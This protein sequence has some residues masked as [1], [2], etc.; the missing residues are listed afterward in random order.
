MQ[1]M[2]ERLC[3]NIFKMLFEN[4]NLFLDST[5]YSDMKNSDNMDIFMPY[6]SRKRQLC[7]NPDLMN[8]HGKYK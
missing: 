4:T 2:E 6:S 1:K 8:N 5:K 3:I 7:F